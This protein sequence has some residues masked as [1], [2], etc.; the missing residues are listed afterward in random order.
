MQT[1]TNNAIAWAAFQ[2]QG[3]WKNILLTAGGF[4][5]T[6]VVG[7]VLV[8]QFATIPL[9]V[10]MYSVLL[11]M[12]A[13]QGALLLLFAPSRIQTF[14]R[15][16]VISGMIESHRLMPLPPANAVLGYVLGPAVQPLALAAAT[17]V[18]GAFVAHTAAVALPRW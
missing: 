10:A 14:V 12:L 9:G 15:R 3:G 6:I 2:L 8:S 1:I 7:V 4:A 16:D 13:L 11:A 18:I 17:L 5:A